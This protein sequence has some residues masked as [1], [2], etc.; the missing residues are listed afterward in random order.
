MV[1]NDVNDSFSFRLLVVFMLVHCHGLLGLTGMLF[2]KDKSAVEKAC[3]QS[4]NT[5]THNPTHRPT[6]IFQSMTQILK[7]RQFLKTN[8]LVMCAPC[9]NLFVSPDTFSITAFQLVILWTVSIGQKGKP[10][11]WLECL[12]LHLVSSCPYA[13]LCLT[14][15]QQ[16][17]HNG[18]KWFAKVKHDGIW[19]LNP[20][21]FCY[22]FIR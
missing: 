16:S 12:Q 2:S 10:L 7:P 8:Q 17:F 3:S 18:V 9:K 19:L 6:M 22:I 4:F 15:E 21:L 5:R 1:N 13:T 14:N 20:L 11:Q